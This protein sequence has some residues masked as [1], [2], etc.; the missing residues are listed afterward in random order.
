MVKAVFAVAVAV[1][2]RNAERDEIFF[3]IIGHS[4][5]PCFEGRLPSSDL[6]LPVLSPSPEHPLQLDSQPV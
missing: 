5:V 4:Q 3:V 6:L 1:V 2:S